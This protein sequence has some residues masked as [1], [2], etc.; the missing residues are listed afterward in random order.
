[1]SKKGSRIKSLKGFGSKVHCED[2][3]SDSASSTETS[4]E[5]KNVGVQ[6][7][8]SSYNKCEALHIRNSEP[9]RKN[10]QVETP[11]TL[12]SRFPEFH[13]SE[14]GPW[15]AMICYEACVRL[16][17]HSLAADGDS[18]ASYFLKNDCVLLRN[19]FGLQSFLL[20]SEE[21]LLGD[22]P[23]ILVSET[24]A[25]KSK[26][27]VG[28]IK[29]QVGKIKMESDPQPGCGT[30][31]SL[32]HEVISQQL[33]ELN[34]TLYS[35]WK[36]VKRVHVAPQV[37]PK[38]SISRKSLE[39]MRA[40]AH[41]LK[42]VSKVLRKEF[43]TSNGAKPRSLQ[44]SQEK[45]SCCM[46]LKS[47]MEE[48]Q[49]KT[50][51]GSG[52]TFFFLPDSIGDDLIVEVRDSKGKFCG[53]VL[54][55]LAA[56]VEEPVRY[57]LIHLCCCVYKMNCSNNL[58]CWLFYQS[59][60]LKW[61]AIYHEPEHER[62]GKIQLHINYLSSLDEKTKCGL[63]A[64][65]SAY[66]LVLEVA[67][68]A[69][70]FQ[71]Q[72]L[73]IKGPWHWMVTQFA[74]LYGIS[75]AYT[76]LRYLSYVMDVASPTKYCIDLIYDFLCPVIMKKNYK[77]TLSHQENRMLAEIDEK[78]QH[79]LA[80]IF[81]NYKSLDESCFSGIKHVFEPPTGTPAP[82]I[83]SAIKLY[84]LLN[85][86]LSQETQ[87]SLCRY[88][89]AALKK[90]SR[91]YFLETNDTLDKGIEDVTSYQK[92]K[93][94]VL[95]LK[96]E[97]STDIAIHKSNVLPRFIDL[98]DLSAAI[99]R[100]DLLKILI[101]YLITW[102]PPSPSPQVV[103]LVITTADF[104]A[105]LTR[106]KLNPIKGGFNARELFHSYITSWIEEKRSA[107]YEFCKSETGKSCSEI[108]GL[109]SPFVDDMYEL[110]NVTLDEYNIIIRR[111]P[112]YGVFL[113]EVVVDTERAMVE[114]LEKQF[115]E[116][117]N[118]LKDSK[119]SALKYVQ[120]LTKRGTYSVPKELGVFL[121]SMKRVLDKLR[122][123]IEERFEEWNSYLSD[124]KKRVLG[125][126]LREVTV[127][128]KAKLRSYTQ[129]LV[130]KLVENMSLQ[131]HMKMKHV[132]HD[133]KETTTEPDVRDRMQSLKDVAD[134]TMEQLHCV[135]SVDVF[136]LICKGIWE[137]MGQ[138]V[139]L[140]LT[141]KKYN[142]TW[143][144][145]LTISVSVL[146]EIFEDKMQSLL[147]DS[148]KGVNFEAPRSIVELR[149]MISEDKKGY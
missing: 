123:S 135:L 126:K 125:E 10:A 134:K 2:H 23:S 52:E 121:N 63:V 47:S 60:K 104:E 14:Q 86:L 3:L 103:D 37:T 99:Y 102:P 24:T 92:L 16:C 133:L 49:V 88:F 68:K 29:L 27:V 18:E 33:E 146:D 41:Y 122:S 87:L 139:I 25:Q 9:K 124:K 107:L 143:H 109:T 144:K 11:G 50:Q 36:A 145:G 95:S 78:V 110:L 137:S 119:I 48:D 61:W 76:K 8:K 89:Q 22:R 43:V 62:I 20:Q 51:P 112:E 94:L 64:E 84:G 111:W 15:S 97:I 132:I 77:A 19:A 69:E 58:K 57:M 138:D 39:Y 42:E 17:L 91:I 140:L 100:T 81:E 30:I 73:V 83:A 56:I 44:A 147:G 96:K 67:M 7:N 108:Q 5:A 40:C 12:P 38:G 130:E 142:V 113:E 90:R 93:S 79:V 13:A 127:L 118:P 101:E 120:R 1:M 45:F 26:K 136:V 71:S 6:D 53:R 80:L 4:H 28:K 115:Y 141:D 21:E 46:K 55:Q 74:S 98:P 82:A 66:D 129:A 59:E 54:A 117:L 106:W 149:S 85:N 65:T 128:L 131:H 34:A 35:G 70:Q 105:D 114:A 75:D 148:G 31:P 116:I 32:K 72:N